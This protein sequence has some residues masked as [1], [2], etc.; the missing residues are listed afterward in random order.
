VCKRDASPTAAVCDDAVFREL[1][2]VPERHNQS[3][4]LEEDHVVVGPGAARPA[5]RLVERPRAPEIGDAEGDQ[6]DA[7]LHDQLTWAT[8]S[9]VEI[10]PE[11][12]KRH[13]EAIESWKRG[14]LRAVSI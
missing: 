5:E 9:S 8:R 4:G 6:A 2:P 10:S 11:S 13:I 7:L 12:S 1:R 14:E 3:A